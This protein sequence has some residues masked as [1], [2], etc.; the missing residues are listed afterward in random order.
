MRVQRADISHSMKETYEQLKTLKAQMDEVRYVNEEAL[1]PIISS[2]L[3]SAHQLVREINQSKEVLPFESRDFVKLIDAIRHSKV[4]TQ[5]VG[6]HQKELIHVFKNL[7][8]A[9]EKA[10]KKA[11]K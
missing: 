8:M 9:I 10:E 2:L 3:K 5:A 1:S 6:A 7:N 4:F 11:L